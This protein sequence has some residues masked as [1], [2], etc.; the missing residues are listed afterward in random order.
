MLQ[1]DTA[2]L[3]YAI[4]FGHQCP[5]V[6]NATLKILLNCPDE[7]KSN[8]STTDLEPTANQTE[9]CSNGDSTGDLDKHYI[10]GDLKVKKIIV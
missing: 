3:E 9:N 1:N 2:K 7:I 5:P 6:A 4:N 10:G 8:C